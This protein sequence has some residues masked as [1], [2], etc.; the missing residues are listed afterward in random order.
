MTMVKARKKA[1]RPPSTSAPDPVLAYALAVG[2]G[3]IVAGPLVRKACARHLA[4]LAEGPKR[5]LIWR[6]DRALHAIEFFPDVLRLPDV[7]KDEVT[8]EDVISFEDAEPFNLHESQKFIVGSLFGWYNGDRTRRFRVGYVEEGKGTGK[9]PLGAGIGL[10][11]LTADGQAKAECYAAAAIKDQA[12]IAYRDATNMVQASDDLQAIIEQHGQKEVYNLLNRKSGGFFKPISAE[13]RGLD[14]KRVHFALIDEVQ[15]HPNALVCDKMR[16]GTKGRRNALILEITNSGFDRTSVCYQ[17]HDYSERVL[18]GT[19]ALSDS[20]AW[21]AFVACLD[22][23]DDPFKDESCWIKANPTLG[24][25]IQPRYLR[26]QVSEARGMPSKESIVRR[27]NFCQW[28]DAE[29]PWI[30]GDLWR[31][32][33]QDF[34]IAEL[35]GRQGFSGLDLSGTR[36]L[37]AHAVAFPN[38]DGSVDAFVEFWTPEATLRERAKV[39]GVP[40]DAWVKTGQVR[41]TPGRAVDYSFVAQRIGE[42]QH[43]IQLEAIAFDPYRIKYFEADLAAAGV[44]VKLVPHGQGYFKASDQAAKEKAKVAGKEPPPDLWMCRSIEL[45]EGLVMKGKLRVKLNQCLQWN[46]ASAVLE[47]DAKNN[48]IFTKRRSKGRIDGLVALAM[49]VGLALNKPETDKPR[50][51]QMFFV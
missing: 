11:M 41:A 5:G 24:I 17:H 16:A 35:N 9:T 51:Y 31:A 30:D 40:Y 25:T 10:Y 23:G 3:Q 7:E 38:D 19:I 39:D 1:K 21:F 37:T 33:E 29:N 18:N 14:G 50:A 45:L 22:E 28:V 26:D 6:L 44:E 47:A 49:A 42:L 46:S 43:D 48:R 20:D 4:D 27:L 8:G 36:D 2:A 12:K 13:K 15:E 32:C 34:D